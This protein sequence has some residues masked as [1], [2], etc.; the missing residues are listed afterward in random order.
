MLLY[1]WDLCS[2]FIT[3]SSSQ[4]HGNVAHNALGEHR[5]W[6]S[7]HSWDTNSSERQQLHELFH[8]MD[9]MRSSLLYDGHEDNVSDLTRRQPITFPRS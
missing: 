5:S 3:F 6:P 2:H 1:V 8:H 7:L 4:E 9:N